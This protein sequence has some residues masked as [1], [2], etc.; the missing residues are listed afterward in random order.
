MNKTVVAISRA[1]LTYLFR[2]NN[3]IYNRDNR[4]TQISEANAVGFDSEI[5]CRFKQIAMR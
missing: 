4:Q 1:I 3:E 2:L 5:G